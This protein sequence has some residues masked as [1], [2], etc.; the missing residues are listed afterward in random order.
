[1]SLSSEE[2]FEIPELPK[3]ERHNAEIPSMSTNVN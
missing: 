3:L 1:M 2:E